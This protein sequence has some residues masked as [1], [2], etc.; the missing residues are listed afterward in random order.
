MDARTCGGGGVAH[1]VLDALRFAV[2]LDDLAP[3]H[4]TAPAALWHLHVCDDG[5]PNP[6]CP[7]LQFSGVYQSVH[8]MDVKDEPMES[9]PEGSYVA[10]GN[11]VYFRCDWAA[12]GL[13][14]PAA[15]MVPGTTARTAAS[16]QLA[17]VLLAAVC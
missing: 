7:C 8:V 6:L 2:Q 5:R 4:A 16:V 1:W 3:H 9:A 15:L 12:G 13:A 14:A 11:E 17:A 10:R